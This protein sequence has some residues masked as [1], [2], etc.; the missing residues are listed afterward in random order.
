MREIN[1]RAWDKEYKKMY[2][3]DFIITP[4]GEEGRRIKNEREENKGYSILPNNL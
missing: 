3:E 1:F 2:F 4:T